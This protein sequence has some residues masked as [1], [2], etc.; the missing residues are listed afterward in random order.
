MGEMNLLITRTVIEVEITEQQKSPVKPTF[1]TM[2]STKRMSLLGDYPVEERESELSEFEG[3]APPPEQRTRI[4]SFAHFQLRVESVGEKLEFL[5]S[6]DPFRAPLRRAKSVDH[7][8]V[9]RS[10]QPSATSGGGDAASEPELTFRLDGPRP[11]RASSA[12]RLTTALERLR[13]TFANRAKSLHVR[14]CSG[15]S[16]PIFQTV[17]KTDPE[18]TGNT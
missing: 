11:R 2:T 9:Q 17:Q 18:K 14:T 6:T 13:R 7:A 4:T 1:P 8:H 3:S 10:A 15:N 16:S 12:E 5:G